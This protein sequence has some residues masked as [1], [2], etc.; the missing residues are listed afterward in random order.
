[1]N[2][3][4]TM[5]V[6]DRDIKEFGL[7]LVSYEAPSY[8]NRKTKGIDIPGAHGTQSVPS[9]LA[10]R[11]FVVTVACAGNDATDIHS[12]IR[13]FFAY[14]YSTQTARKI[15]FTDNASVV[16]FAI[17]DSPGNHKIHSGSFDGAMTEMK[18]TF[19]ML[20]PFIYEIL[21]EKMSCIMSTDAITIISNEAHDCPAIFSIT[22]TSDSTISDVELCVNNETARFLVTLNPGDVLTLDTDEYEVRL[23]DELH[24]EIWRGEM[25]KLN[26]GNNEIRQ[27]NAENAPL[28]VT[29]EFTKRWI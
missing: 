20:D 24:L 29:V 5:I 16:R 14:M 8:A 9:T 13:E 15:M 3:S 19:F 26:N 18:L 23:N 4:Y 1:M 25:P 12:Q 6:D 2:N 10:S 17:L 22:N 11:S 7:K 27:R 21:P 28:S